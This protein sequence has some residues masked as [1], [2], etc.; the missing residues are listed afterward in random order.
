M[1]WFPATNALRYEPDVPTSRDPRVVLNLRL[2]GLSWVKSV[3][4]KTS[5]A[6]N[7]NP[8]L[9]V[10]YA[11]TI[12]LAA[13]PVQAPHGRPFPRICAAARAAEIVPNCPGDKFGSFIHLISHQKIFHAST[14]V[15]Q[16]HPNEGASSNFIFVE[17][18]ANNSLHHS[19]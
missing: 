7:P 13:E 11:L 14:T 1:D 4:E 16:R 6:C 18:G 12:L 15:K 19:L 9:A 10:Y 17:A 3:E 2:T 8:L 5:N